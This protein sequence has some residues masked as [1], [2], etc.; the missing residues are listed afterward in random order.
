LVLQKHLPGVFRSCQA[1]FIGD[2]TECQPVLQ[3]FHTDRINKVVRMPDIKR[4]E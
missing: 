4:E 3:R 2:Y 1:I